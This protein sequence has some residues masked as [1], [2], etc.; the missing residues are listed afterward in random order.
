LAEPP[1][2]VLL[3][4]ILGVFRLL[5]TLVGIFSM[6]AYAVARRTREIGVRMAFG[7]RP[8]QVVAVVICCAGWPASFGVVGG[9][10]GTYYATRVITSFLFQTTPHDPATLVGVVTLLG[11]AACLA[12]WLAARPAASVHPVAPL[13]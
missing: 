8:V 3:L 11:A 5:L 12:A 4:N 10:V 7:A 6:T 9:L 1:H 13:R 2:R